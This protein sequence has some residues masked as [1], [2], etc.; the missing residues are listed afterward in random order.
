M[1]F[2]CKKTLTSSQKGFIILC[3]LLHFSNLLDH[4]EDFS[5]YKSMVAKVLP[6][7]FETGS[8]KFQKFL[9]MY[10]NLCI[11]D[12]RGDKNPQLLINYH[13]FPKYKHF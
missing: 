11:T 12:A 3:F 6:N 9:E 2:T 8:E 4:F 10:F 13:L 5:T 1:L 7:S